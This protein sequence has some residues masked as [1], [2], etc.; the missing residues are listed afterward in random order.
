MKLRAAIYVRVSTTEQAEEGYSIGAQTEKLHNFA[1]AKDYTV[2]S[3][4]TD[5]GYSGAKLDRPALQEMI[6]D[7]E[8]KQIDIV[9]V[10]KLDRLSRS[11]KNTLFLIE[12]VFLKNNVQFVSMLESFDTSTPFGRAMIGILSV[13]AQ[14]ERD[15]ISERMN[16][17]KVERAK[18]GYFHGG[19]GRTR[20]PVGYDYENGLLLVNDYEA[21]IVRE[22]FEMYLNGVGID[23]ISGMITEKYPS[24]RKFSPSLIRNI[25][26][27]NL[28]ISEIT[29]DGKTYPGLHQSIVDKEV[30]EKVRIKRAESLATNEKAFVSTKLLTGL[31]Y[32]TYCGS[33][34]VA[35][36]SD[37]NRRYYTCYSK[38]GFPRHM[39]K[40]PN[41]PSRLHREEELNQAVIEEIKKLTLAD[42]EPEVDD[43]KQNNNDAIKLQIDDLE[44]QADRLLDLYQ[45]GQIP[46][47]VL[48]ARIEKLNN[49][50]RKLAAMLQEEKEV[51]PI[52]ER[53]AHLKQLKSIDWENESMEIKR[54]VLKAAISR[55]E[56]ENE[57]IRIE[58]KI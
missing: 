33:R 36:G 43:E 29:Y 47:Y 34:M 38:R 17:G 13:F 26:V 55:I 20:I 19:G 27:N 52:A 40:D 10:Y 5:P 56:V 11:Q 6:K 12:D 14:L 41:C 45:V 31:L 18:A 28:Y 37:K 39:V 54:K 53:K 1:S 46:I 57:K 25:L 42:L 3:V 22:V 9:L 49:D 35:N 44:K 24:K 15:A 16:M 51:A 4:Y 32:C 2:V 48:N 50:K 8:N 21:V 30:F 7:I 23:S 58:W